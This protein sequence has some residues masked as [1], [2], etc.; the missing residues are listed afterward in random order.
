MRAGRKRLRAVTLAG[1]KPPTVFDLRAD[2]IGGKPDHSAPIEVE[3]PL[4]KNQKIVV[5]RKLRDDPL[6]RLHARSHIDESEYR[7]GRHWQSAYETAELSGA[8]AIDT[9][10]ENVD[11]GQIAR[12]AVTDAQAKALET[13]KIGGAAILKNLGK[14]GDEVLRSVLVHGMTAAQVSAA[15]GFRDQNS[16]VYYARIFRECLDVLAKAYGFSRFNDQRRRIT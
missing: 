7:A 1:T 5:F 8:K 10:R 9:T 11:G 15:R 13:L 6:G 2:Y 4:N 3:N 16:E 12:S 14:T